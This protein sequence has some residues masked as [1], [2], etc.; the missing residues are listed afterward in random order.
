MKEAE[1]A[2]V[3]ALYDIKHQIHDMAVDP[4]IKGVS[5]YVSIKA[6]D[7]IIAKHVKKY[8]EAT[9]KDNKEG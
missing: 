5:P 3:Q 4:G 6:V 1:R 8:M 9:P 2:I 7:A